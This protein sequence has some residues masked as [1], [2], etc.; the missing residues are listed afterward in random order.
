MPRYLVERS[1]PDGFTLPGPGS[2]AQDRENFF[3][4][5]LLDGVTWLVTYV[6]EGQK[7]SYCVYDAPN[8]EALR[9]AA[10]RNGLPIDRISEVRILDPYFFE[11]A[12]VRPEV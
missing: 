8:P 2:V 3:E 7:K 5:N 12:R 1:Y 10:Q 11:P 9:R 4:N 6:V